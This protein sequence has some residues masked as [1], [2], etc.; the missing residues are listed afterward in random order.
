MAETYTGVPI[1]IAVPD[2][3][4]ALVDWTHLRL[5]RATSPGG[6]FAL[7]VGAGLPIPLVPRQ[8]GY[9]YQDTT[10]TSATTTYYYRVSRYNVQ[11][12]AESVLSE[13][14]P[15][16][17]APLVTR[18]ELR[19]RAA[20]KLG[21]YMVPPRE[22]TFPGPSGTTT[23]AGSATTLVCAQ[24]SSSLLDANQYRSYTV[25]LTSGTYAGVERQVDSLAGGTFT[26]ADPFPGAPGISVT[27]EGYGTL[28]ATEWN[29]AID[30][31]R[32]SMWQPLEETIAA[33]AD[34]A[35]N[36]TETEF[37]LPPYI[38]SA[39]QVTRME[40]RTGSTARAHTLVGGYD[41]L[42]NA[43]ATGGVTL[44]LPGGVGSTARLTLRGWRNPPPLTADSDA[45]ALSPRLREVFEAAVLWRAARR[46]AEKDP[47]DRW[48]QKAATLDL[49]RKA[50]MRSFGER[51]DRGRRIRHS[52]MVAIGGGRGRR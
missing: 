32:L 48:Q 17:N 23:G 6:T 49:R 50:L 44:Y 41:Y 30:E 36:W 24:Y 26:M 9:F 43:N 5:Y 19:Q 21:M 11:T 38:E 10:A 16:G 51:R 37:A 28:T 45:V 15:S 27:F 20:L 3:D 12:L 31:A 35:G 33:V 40:T 46:I 8:H 47:S 39:D 14:I 22:F 29:L 42:L 1:T 25:L 13:P 2:I 7:V 52:P 4:Q 34:P 18:A